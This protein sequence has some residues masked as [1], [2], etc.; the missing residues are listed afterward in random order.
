MAKKKKAAAKR[1]KMYYDKDANL[2]SIKNKK[3]AVIGCGSQG[4]AHALN[5]QDSGLDVRVGLRKGSKTWPMAKKA[6]LNVMT[7]AQAADEADIIMMLVPD[8][9]APKVY[10]EDIKQ[11]LQPG[12]ALAFAHG[13]N[14][15]FKTIEPPRHVDVF[16]IAP[17]G[18]GHLVRSIYQ[19]KFGV[20]ALLAVHQDYTGKAKKMALA[21]AKALGATRAGVIETTFTEETETDLFGEQTILCGGVS[22]LIQTAFETL[23]EAGYQPQVAYFECL[24]EL[25]LITDLIHIGGLSAMRYSVSDTAEWGDYIAGSR[26]I[27]QSTKREMKKIL[28]EIQTGKFAREWIEENET[29]MKKFKKYRAQEADHQIEKIGQPLREMMR[30]QD[31]LQESRN[32]FLEAGNKK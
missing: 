26:I 11:A 4:H 7:N 24:H 20:P 13:F 23:V 8:T 21:Y 1:P 6:G 18:P 14:I 12:K 15:R 28:K 5:L 32:K 17:K 10:E 22:K 30:V 31:R 27:N 9:A 29:G 25:K 16:M 2:I 19:Q 3:I